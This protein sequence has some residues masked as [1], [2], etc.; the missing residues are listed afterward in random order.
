ME[1]LYIW[2][3]SYKNIKQQGFNFSPLYDFEFKITSEKGSPI[4]GELIDHKNDDQRTELETVHNGFFGDGISNVTAIVGE[5]G[6]G[7]TSL[8]EFISEL[9]PT[10]KTKYKAIIVFKNN[11]IYYHSSLSLKIHFPFYALKYDEKSGQ[12]ITN[13]PITRVWLSNTT[14]GTKNDAFLSTNYSHDMSDESIFLRYGFKKS[15]YNIDLMSQ[16]YRLNRYVRVIMQYQIKFINEVA[17]NP[18]FILPFS[19][20]SQLKISGNHNIVENNGNNEVINKF[21]D[22]KDD[23]VDI[24]SLIKHIYKQISVVLYYMC[25][26]KEIFMELLNFPLN[27]DDYTI[28]NNLLKFLSDVINNDK[29]RFNGN[30][31][32]TQNEQETINILEKINRIENYE[33]KIIFKS[34]NSL[35]ISIDNLNETDNFLLDF[36]IFNNDIEIAFFYYDWVIENNDETQTLSSGEYVL[37]NTFAKFFHIFNE[38][39]NEGNEVIVLIDEGEL[40][41]HPQWQKEYLKNLIDVLPKI[42]EGKTIQIILTSHS[43]FLVSDLPKENIIFLAKGEKGECLVKNSLNDMKQ[44]FGANIH[45]LLTDSFFMQDKGLMGKFAEGKI[46][47]VMEKLIDSK[48]IAEKDKNEIRYIISC[49]GEP[50]IKRKLM[51]LYDDKTKFSVEDRIDRLEKELEELKNNKNRKV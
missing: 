11:D 4:T 35:C 8:L 37:L 45:T 29:I 49:I 18:Q 46:N 6:S 15:D 21:I 30:L 9:K 38:I 50:I 2:I 32:N 14:F 31:F 13:I 5:N 12:D 34:D 42:F 36:F 23:I 27:T 19:L 16:I 33:E 17:D 1:L 41:L 26:N 25:D 51:Q 40:G 22:D 20:P 7:K 43:P 44:T 48:E 47:M 3:D 24:P 39:K 10:I 28:K